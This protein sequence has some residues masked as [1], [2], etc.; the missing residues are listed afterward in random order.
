MAADKK[1]DSKTGAN[2]PKKTG[3]LQES[4][5]DSHR[6]QLRDHLSELWEGYRLQRH[7][8][9]EDALRRFLSTLR[10]QH[11]FQRQKEETA[12]TN[13]RRELERWKKCGAGLRNGLLEF[14]RNLLTLLP[15]LESGQQN[16]APPELRAQL[17]FCVGGLQRLATHT[18]PPENRSVTPVFPVGLA[19]A[20]VGEE[21]LAKA[22]SGLRGAGAPNSPAQLLG[23]LEKVSEGWWYSHLQLAELYGKSAT[24]AHR[25]A[26]IA[27]QDFCEIVA[28]RILPVLDA[29]NDAVLSSILE[30]G[31]PARSG[32]LRGARREL[33]A[34]LAQADVFPMEARPGDAFDALKHHAVSSR[35]ARPP[36]HMLI[37]KML[38]NGY[39]AGSE[40]IRPA[41]V[42][43]SVD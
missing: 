23:H 29:L 24:D 30:S 32:A 38:R 26:V 8:V 41:D 39:R 6:I 10:A 15:G 20:E 11:D 12:F 9:V 1:L 25:L 43:V 7:A 27:R 42:E 37:A 16:D 14:A 22:L 40:I 3:S 5:L 21:A 18:F 33:I 4:P 19:V 2:S 34:L 13:S 35:L 28:Q 17:S 31:P 36:G